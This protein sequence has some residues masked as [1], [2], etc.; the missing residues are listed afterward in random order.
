MTMLRAK[1]YSH[2]PIERVNFTSMTELE[3]RCCR[4]QGDGGAHIDALITQNASDWSAL[5]QMV[6][7]RRRTT[8]TLTRSPPQRLD[9][10]GGDGHQAGDN[11]AGM[12]RSNPASAIGFSPS[13]FPVGYTRT[14]GTWWRDKRCGYKSV[15]VAG[16]WATTSCARSRISPATPFVDA[17][18]CRLHRAIMTRRRSH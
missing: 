12:T 2:V 4:A 9:D 11:L 17:T 6:H 10:G 16:R 5:C 15:G 7:R 18:D 1:G 14:H 13:F 8:T 3:R